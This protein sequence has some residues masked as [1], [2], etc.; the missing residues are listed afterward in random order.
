MQIEKDERF[1]ENLRTILRFIAS[2]NKAQAR[3]FN[4]ALFQSD[5]DGLCY[6]IS[7]STIALL[8]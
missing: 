8:Q 4:T 6:A 1:V 5:L 3:R 2:D 7:F